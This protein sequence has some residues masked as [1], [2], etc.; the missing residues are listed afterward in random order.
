MS[1]LLDPNVTY[2]LLVLGFVLGILA[3][4]TPGTGLLEIGALF[5]VALAGYGIYQLSVNWWALVMMIA[6]IVPL[7]LS[8]RKPKQWYWLIL[9]AILLIAGSIFLFPSNAGTEAINPFFAIL[10][11]LAAIGLTWL[12]GRKSFDAMKLKPSQDLRKLIGQTGEARTPIHFEGT[13]Y[14]A[15]EEWTARSQEEIPAGTLV[16]V[17]DREGLVLIVEPVKE[18]SK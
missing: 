18:S 13:V 2:L 5:A 8:V 4:F 1:F 17:V 11:S 3:L 16:K 7:V 6:G 14:L 9:S 10:V 12:I 15:S